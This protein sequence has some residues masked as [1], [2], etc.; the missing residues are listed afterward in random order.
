MKSCEEYQEGGGI[1]QGDRAYVAPTG[2][3]FVSENVVRGVLPRVLEELLS[4][5]AMLKKA[6]K[7]YKRKVPNLAPSILRQLEA[8]QLALKYVANVTYGELA[9]ES[10][11]CKQSYANL[12][13]VATRIHIGNFLRTLRNANFGGQHCRVR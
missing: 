10:F 12:P 1:S 3:I 13:N 9:S 4:T 6:A 11:L 8:R 5:R 7:E 2:A